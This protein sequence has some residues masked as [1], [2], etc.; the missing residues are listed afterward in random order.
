VHDL[1]M[2][3][4]MPPYTQT[5]GADKQHEDAETEQPPPG[6]PAPRRLARNWPAAR[7]STPRSRPGTL[8]SGRY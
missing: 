2:L 8:A 3:L 1:V 7:R 6:T 5:E 4:V